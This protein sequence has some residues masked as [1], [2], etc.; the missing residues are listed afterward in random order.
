MRF[1]V[2]L[3]DGTENYFFF[4]KSNNKLALQ[5]KQ[6]DA[7]QQQKDYQRRLTS[8]DGVYIP[9]NLGSLSELDKLC[10]D[11]PQRNAG[12]TQ[13]DMFRITWGSARGCA[14]TGAGEVR[15]CISISG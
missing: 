5:E 3:I 12:A 1:R 11:R 9:Q 7:A 4:R 13:E 14:T 6:Q 10:R 8:I 2:G 15:D